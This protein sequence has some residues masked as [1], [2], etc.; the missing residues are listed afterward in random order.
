MIQQRL[1]NLNSCC[2]AHYTAEGRIKTYIICLDREINT[3]YDKVSGYTNLLS[4]KMTHIKI[5]LEVQSSCIVL[6]ECRFCGSL[7]VGTQA[8]KLPSRWSQVEDRTN[9]MP[10]VLCDPQVVHYISK[11]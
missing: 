6:T 2:S 3:L 1:F 11:Q 9:M 5:K 4:H 7:R 10:P 8:D